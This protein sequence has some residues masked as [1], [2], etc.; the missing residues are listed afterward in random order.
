MGELTRLP[1]RFFL[2]A[3]KYILNNIKTYSNMTKFISSSPFNHFAPHKYI[4]YI[5]TCSRTDFIDS[6][7]YLEID[8]HQIGKNGH[9]HH[10]Y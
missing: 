3:K 7:Q 5:N 6:G 2:Y 9:V 4:S 1:S 10:E 8:N